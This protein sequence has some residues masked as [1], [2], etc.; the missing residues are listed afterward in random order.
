MTVE[1]VP[2]TTTMTIITTTARGGIVSAPEAECM[3]VPVGD[4][5][6]TAF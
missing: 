4:T 2:A 5:I 1:G 6:A 3:I